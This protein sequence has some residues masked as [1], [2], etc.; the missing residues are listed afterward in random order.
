MELG[1]SQSRKNLQVAPILKPFWKM[2]M[3]VATGVIFL[4][5]YPLLLVNLIKTLQRGEN[6]GW[7]SFLVTLAPY[8]L[9]AW[10]PIRSW[11]M[12]ARSMREMR[13]E[14]GA[15]QTVVVRHI[16][17]GLRGAHDLGVQLGKP[18][19]VFGDLRGIL[20]ASSLG[21][22]FWNCEMAKTEG[23]LPW[24]SIQAIEPTRLDTSLWKSNGIRFTCRGRDEKNTSFAVGIEIRSEKF[25]GALPIRKKSAESFAE[26]LIRTKNEFQRSGAGEE[27]P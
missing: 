4:I 17:F 3:Y 19:F 13:K 20:F 14:H 5:V 21:L 11:R 6:P 15:G 1:P 25:S 7:G 12:G 8:A 2:P 27:A 23:V 9:L 10:L 26:S 22:V 16:R 18:A 24:E